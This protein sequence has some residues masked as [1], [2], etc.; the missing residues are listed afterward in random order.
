[1]ELYQEEEKEVEPVVNVYSESSKSNHEGF[2]KSLPS[3]H[4]EKRI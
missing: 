4:K 1:V 3:S 2:S